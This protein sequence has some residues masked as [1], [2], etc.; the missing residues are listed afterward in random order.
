LRLFQIAQFSSAVLERFLKKVYSKSRGTA[1]E[2]EWDKILNPDGYSANAEQSE[3]EWA[4]SAVTAK[5]GNDR[6]AG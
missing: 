3:A 5:T 2:R 6:L 1:I 4:Q